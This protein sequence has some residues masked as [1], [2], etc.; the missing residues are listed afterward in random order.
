MNREQRKEEK[1]KETDR[2]R[3]GAEGEMK[4]I[5]LALMAKFHYFFEVSF[6]VISFCPSK[7]GKRKHL[8]LMKKKIK[9]G[10]KK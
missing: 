6:M 1:D 2:M 4:T 7:L 8:T 3:M 10:R 5:S 9:T